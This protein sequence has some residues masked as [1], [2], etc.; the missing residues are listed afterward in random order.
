V[1]RNRAREAA[2]FTPDLRVA[3][4]Q[5]AGR[6]ADPSAFAKAAADADVVVTS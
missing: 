6:P 5:G 4:H 1:V 3:V 2:R